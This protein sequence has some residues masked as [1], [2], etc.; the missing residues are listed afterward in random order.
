[1]YPIRGI[2]AGDWKWEIY[3]K[4]L[5]EG[6]AHFG[7]EVHPFNTSSYFTSR[8]TDRLQHKT[9]CGPLIRKISADLMTITG[10]LK[11]DFI[12][13]QRPVLFPGNLIKK[14]KLI[15]NSTKVLVF[16][17]DNPFIHNLK[18]LRYRNYFSM[19]PLADIVYVYRPANID[20]AKQYN[21]KSVNLLLPYYYS[22]LH[23]ISGTTPKKTDVIFIGHFEDDGRDM[24][25]NHLINNNI[26]LKIIGTGWEK[27]LIEK[28]YIYPP[29]YGG[30]YV[31]LI[32]QSKI[33]IAF[34]SK[35][36]RDVYT[37]RCFEIP[38]AGTFL[39]TE[40]SIELEK[41]LAKDIDCSY[42][43]TK[44]DLLKKIQYYLKN[45]IKRK[46]IAKN[47]NAKIIHYHSNINRAEQILND[48][49]MLEKNP[50]E[51]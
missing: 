5:S 4:A 14:I 31:N 1:M 15:N 9:R 8:P 29:Q 44:E 45:E 40:E 49:A 48:L 42:F 13:F 12:F 3:E 6:F 11:P 10:F 20:Q 37:R 33:A 7:V 2:I 22:G 30:K 18:Y 19:L 16:H 39:L 46:E 32:K 36:N 28:K 43:N 47:G 34:Y 17:N 41:I 24:V 35:L 23:D 38:A 27:S 26:E 50:P 51:T 21:A 25:L